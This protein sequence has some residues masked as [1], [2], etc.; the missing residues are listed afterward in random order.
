MMTDNISLQLRVDNKFNL[1]SL[2]ESSE[3]Y[4]ETLILHL[5]NLIINASTMN[6]ISS[7]HSFVTLI[8]Q[9]IIFI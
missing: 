5:I 8:N 1:R 7:I 6:L 4:D 9:N 3:H 2:Y